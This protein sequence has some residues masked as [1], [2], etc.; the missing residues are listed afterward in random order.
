MK[1]FLRYWSENYLEMFIFIFSINVFLH[2]VFFILAHAL[3]GT[4]PGF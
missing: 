1:N 2:F 3:Y 4:M